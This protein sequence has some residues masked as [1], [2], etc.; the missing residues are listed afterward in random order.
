MDEK[1]GHKEKLF[2]EFPPVSKEEWKEQVVKI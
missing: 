1:P 2:K